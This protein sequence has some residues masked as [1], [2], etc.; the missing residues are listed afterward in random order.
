MC[1]ESIQPDAPVP[2]SG[3][4]AIDLWLDA[5]EGD[6]SGMAMISLSKNLCKRSGGIPPLSSKQLLAFL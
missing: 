5:A 4:A 1:V 6:Y 3:P 2:L